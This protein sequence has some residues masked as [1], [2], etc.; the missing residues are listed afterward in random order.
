MYPHKSD[1]I[2]TGF[3]SRAMA[4]GGAYTAISD[5]GSATYYNPAGIANPKKAG[6]VLG[7]AYV[8]SNLSIQGKPIPLLAP[9]AM[10][11]A[12]RGKIPFGGILKDRIAVG[13]GMY[14]PIWA[15]AR[16]R[17][18]K[19]EEPFFPLFNDQM[20]RS[21]FL[22]TI[23]VSILDGLSVGFGLN[24]FT[25]VHGQVKGVEGATRGI[26]TEISE[27]LT[28]VVSWQAGVHF[29]PTSSLRLGFCFRQEFDLPFTSPISTSI[30]GNDLKLELAL[31]TIYT[32]PEFALGVAYQVLSS[33]LWSLDVRYSLWSR[34]PSAYINVKAQLPIEL[35]G[36]KLQADI[37]PSIP[38]PQF[39]N[40][41]AVHTG[42][43]YTARL[44]PTLNLLLR[45][46]YSFENTPLPEQSG[47]T[48]MVDGNKHTVSLGLGLSSKHF[49]N[50]PISLDLHGQV[51]FFSE[52][53]SK[54]KTALL[55]D[56]S[57]EKGFQT[58]N[59][60]YPTLQGGGQIIT[61]GT[62]LR[63]GF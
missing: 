3:G 24:V 27:K 11:A 49:P 46:G 16:I 50:H 29:R 53:I 35:F 63:L 58:Q 57:P 13:I 30:Q 22:P 33:L 54:K 43:E 5:D 48:N 36:N 1:A 26:E 62:T 2:R 6:V 15:V 32:P 56:D 21:V 31:R 17:G 23:A 45:L 52:H 19:L 42:G 20:N 41:V 44:L 9:S 34:Y 14:L 25:A 37:L 10:T 59:P 8:T 28:T 18:R 12:V 47:R 39:S 51:L 38:E 60:G 7:F 4:L 40:T 61:V 55:P